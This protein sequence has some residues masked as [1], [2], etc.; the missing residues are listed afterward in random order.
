ML[1]AKQGDK[2]DFELRQGHTLEVTKEYRIVA[3]AGKT[4]LEKRVRMGFHVEKTAIYLM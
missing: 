4:L 3:R 1:P 2:A